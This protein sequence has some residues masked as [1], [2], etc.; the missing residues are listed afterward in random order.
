MRLFHLRLSRGAVLVE[1]LAFG[2]FRISE[3]WCGSRGQK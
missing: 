1:D 2:R 3:G